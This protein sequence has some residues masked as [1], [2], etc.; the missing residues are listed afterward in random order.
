MTTILNTLYVTTEGAQLY[1]DHETVVVKIEGEKRL[2]LPLLH[3]SGVV[4]MG[5]IYVSPDLLAAC[6]AANI[7][8]AFFSITGRFLARVEGMPGGSVLLRRAQ[9]RAASSDERSLAI[10]RAMV[11]GKIS[12][13]RQFLLHARRDAPADRKEALLHVG[14]RMADHLRALQGV[15]TMDGLRGMEGIAAR[16]YFSVFDLLCKR[17]E[18]TL[19]F[20]GR[21]RRPP[22]DRVNALLSFGYALLMQDCAGALAGVGL[23]PAVGFLHEDR[24]GRLGLA[25]DLM[26]ELRCPVVDRLVLA[27]LNRGQVGP[28]DFVADDGGGWRLTDESRKAFLIAYQEAKSGELLH[29]FLEQRISWG[30]VP[31]VQARLLARALR[32][33]LD[34]YPPFAFR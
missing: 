14:D 32:D 2:Q 20:G 34:A 31:H 19:R 21:S 9:H 15:E 25:L 30:K 23:D 24:P 12:G 10:A 18:E 11:A 5:P 4:C 13:A 22:K 26:E 33:D 28:D 7:H 6:C 17:T 29:P 8:V 3:L 1:K 16:D 27:M